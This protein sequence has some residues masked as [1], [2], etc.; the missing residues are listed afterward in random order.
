MGRQTNEVHSVRKNPRDVKQ[1]ADRK[2][3]KPKQAGD[4][5]KCDNFGKKRHGKIASFPT[6]GRKCQKANH[7]AKVCRSC[8]LQT[9]SID[10]R[11]SKIQ[12][13]SSE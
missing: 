4:T 1:Q 7:F 6:Y 10:A 8:K 12:L 11:L 5:R 3:P 2:S 13:I 9:D